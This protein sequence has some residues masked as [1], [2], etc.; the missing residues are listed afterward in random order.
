M[1]TCTYIQVEL[2]YWNSEY[3]VCCISSSIVFSFIIIMLCCIILCVCTLIP[4]ECWGMLQDTHKHATTSDALV[5]VPKGKICS[6]S[7]FAGPS[8]SP[9]KS[10][11][12]LCSNQ[13]QMAHFFVSLF[14]RFKGLALLWW[15][16]RCPSLWSQ[17]QQ[18][19]S[20]KQTWLWR[21]SILRVAATLSCRSW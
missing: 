4:S 6:F 21:Q 19:H 3:Y 2:E 5:L 7:Y 16:S 1:Y 9:V 15:V 13:C 18:M 17:Q 20:W 12:S 8:G 10:K 11:L 14:C